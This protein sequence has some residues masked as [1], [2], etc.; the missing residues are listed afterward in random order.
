VREKVWRLVICRMMLSCNH[1][2]K[3]PLLPLK[4]NTLLF[5][6]PNFPPQPHWLCFLTGREFDQ[7]LRLSWAVSVTS[8]LRE[9]KESAEFAKVMMEN[10]Q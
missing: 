7:V 6:D 2:R 9:G 4:G 3:V 10:P 1:I 5:V 8:G